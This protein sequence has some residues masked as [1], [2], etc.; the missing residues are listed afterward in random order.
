MKIRHSLLALTLLV[1]TLYASADGIKLQSLSPMSGTGNNVTQFEAGM[2]FLTEKS[3]GDAQMLQGLIEALTESTGQT[4]GAQ[5]IVADSGDVAMSFDPVTKIFY[6][7]GPE[8]QPMNVA[9]A[10]L[11][12]IVVY[13]NVSDTGS[14]QIDMSHYSAGIYMV[15][16]SINNQIIK[17][18]KIVI[19]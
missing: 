15:G 17:T 3:E 2:P 12:G 10:N 14:E 9:V 19:K 16:C 18:Q 13:N 1:P 11:N 8:G 5:V 4:T 6:I 7:N